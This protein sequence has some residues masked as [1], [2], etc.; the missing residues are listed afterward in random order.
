MVRNRYATYR[1][2]R[3]VQG[4]VRLVVDAATGAIAQRLDY[5]SFGNVLLDTNPGFQPFGFQS[6]GVRFLFVASH[7][8]IL[9]SD[10]CA[11]STKLN[12]TREFSAPSPFCLEKDGAMG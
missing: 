12:R 11:N 3:D 9:D 2:I 5:D 6:G 7:P 10:S 4:S 1:F 8:R